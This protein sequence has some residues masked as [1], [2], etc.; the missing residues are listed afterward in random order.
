MGSSGWG[1]NPT[2]GED[3]ELSPHVKTQPG[4]VSPGMEAGDLQPGTVRRFVL[5]LRPQPVAPE[6]RPAGGVMCAAVGRKCFV[7]RKG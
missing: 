6:L 3:T 5:W 7:I 4:E 2:G 1:L